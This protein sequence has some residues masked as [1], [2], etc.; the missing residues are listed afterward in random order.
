MSCLQKRISSFQT[1]ENTKKKHI[2]KAWQEVFPQN[3]K[4]NRKSYIKKRTEMR[5]NFPAKTQ[6]PNNMK[7]FL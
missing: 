4:K 1:E 3:K 2:A 7:Y 5:N 6:H